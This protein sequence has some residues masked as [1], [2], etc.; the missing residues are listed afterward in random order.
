MGR[1]RK[2]KDGEIVRGVADGSV[3]YV[4]VDYESSDEERRYRI[5]PL[6]NKKRRRGDA[7]WTRAYVL[8]STG[9]RSGTASLKTYR[10]NESMSERGCSCQ[11]CIHEAYDPKSWNNWGDWR[12]PDEDDKSGYTRHDLDV[13]EHPER[14]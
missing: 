11:C 5:I 4:V 7:F 1:H 10:A 14:A 12:S 9:E 8:E 3:K 2:F 6:D 13:H